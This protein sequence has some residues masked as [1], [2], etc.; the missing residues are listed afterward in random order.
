M[1][2][3]LPAELLE[4]ITSA[5]L[6]G[7][8]SALARTCTIL[9]AVSTPLLYGSIA[10]GH[11]TDPTRTIQCMQ[12]LA[13]NTKNARLVR[14]FGLI[15]RGYGDQE[16][17]TAL[18][19]SAPGAF[20]QMVN[21]TDLSLEF[22]SDVDLFILKRAKF[23]L[24]RL[25]CR[26]RIYSR[27]MIRPFLEAQPSIESLSVIV[28]DSQNFIDLGPDVLPALREI[29]AP[30]TSLQRILP[31]RLSSLKTV[32]CLHSFR[33]PDRSVRAFTRII[34]TIRM[35]PPDASIDLGFNISFSEGLV[36]WS[37]VRALLD[38]GHRAPWVGSLT[39]QAERN[40]SFTQGI[41][42]V[43][44][45]S[46]IRNFQ[47]L[48]TLVI[49]S[50]RQAKLQS[51]AFQDSVSLPLPDESHNVAEHKTYL[52]AW[53]SARPTLRRVEFPTGAYTFGES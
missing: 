27:Y 40:E 34:D 37:V 52:D 44:V 1:L 43:N 26:L 46:A 11:P 14:N 17:L 24:R 16:D 49:L 36:R 19:D 29:A 25:H 51:N 6:A 50:E 30:S 53:R 8:I 28:T 10:L 22:G 5:L 42:L 18:Y 2:D 47:N 15:W 21:L 35:I 45:T 3:T 9:H 41:L 13:H 20:E 23:K 39:L 12:T 48:H 31:Q 33:R 7:D 4:F 38:L 32:R